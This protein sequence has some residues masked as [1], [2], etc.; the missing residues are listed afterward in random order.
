M[1]MRVPWFLYRRGEDLSVGEQDVGFMGD[2]SRYVIHAPLG[3]GVLYRQQLGPPP[4]DHTYQRHVLR[5][6][7]PSGIGQIGEQ[8]LIANPLVPIPDGPAD[9]GA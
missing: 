2:G 7:Q 9:M 5:V 6:G 1:A 4:G 8:G 3:S